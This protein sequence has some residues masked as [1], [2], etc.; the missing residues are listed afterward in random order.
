M[1]ISSCDITSCNDLVVLQ[2][3]G[4]DREKS[5]GAPEGCRQHGR[6]WAQL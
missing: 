5:V 4:W 6:L 2:Q 1:K 3:K